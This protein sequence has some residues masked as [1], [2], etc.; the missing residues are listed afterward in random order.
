[1]DRFFHAAL[2]SYRDH[3][4]HDWGRV[5]FQGILHSMAFASV[6]SKVTIV[7]L[8]HEEWSFL[9]VC[10]VFV[11]DFCWYFMVLAGP[12]KNE[13]IIWVRC[14]WHDTPLF[15]GFIWI[16]SRFFCKIEERSE[17]VTL[18]TGSGWG[19]KRKNERG[20]SSSGTYQQRGQRKARENIS[21]DSFAKS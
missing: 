17:S 19:V 2:R 4:K 10:Q 1:M 6:V 14:P 3:G 18:W 12:L 9:F 8:I 20:V 21:I 15:D 13:I 5:W 7:L 11:E 16:N